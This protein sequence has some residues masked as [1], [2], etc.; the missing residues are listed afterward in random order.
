MCWLKVSIATS[1]PFHWWCSFR[2]AQC[3]WLFHAS[4]SIQDQR[5]YQVVIIRAT[6][7][8][9]SEIRSAEEMVVLFSFEN[10]ERVRALRG[11]LTV[12]E[13]ERR[14]NSPSCRVLSSPTLL[15]KPH[16]V[17]KMIPGNSKLLP[18]KTMH[19][20]LWLL[21]FFL[22]SSSSHLPTTGT[23]TGSVFVRQIPAQGPWCPRAC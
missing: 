1:L 17:G 6:P 2:Q 8:L 3:F 9:V 4:K 15:A 7:L 22:Y 12:T 16:G 13:E 21:W 5:G 20:G 18:S 14:L 11:T 10:V 23:F 19:P